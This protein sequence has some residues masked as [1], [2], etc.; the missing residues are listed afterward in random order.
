MSQNTK[1]MTELTPGLV[2]ETKK[3]CTGKSR[4]DGRD[5]IVDIASFIS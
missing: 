2:P 1:S 3:N 4:V 5:N